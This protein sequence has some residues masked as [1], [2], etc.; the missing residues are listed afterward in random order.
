MKKSVCRGHRETEARTIFPKTQIQLN[1]D[2]QEVKILFIFSIGN[3]TMSH[4]VEPIKSRLSI[5]YGIPT[6]S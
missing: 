5:S 1:N 4:N 2:F 3:L 6:V